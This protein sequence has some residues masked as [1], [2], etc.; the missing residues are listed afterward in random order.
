MN[1]PVTSAVELESRR[2]AI[3]ACFVFQL[4]IRRYV[5]WDFFDSIGRSDKNSVRVK[6]FRFAL[7][8]RHCSMRS[9]LRIC[10]TS[11]LMGCSSCVLTARASSVYCTSIPSDLAVLRMMTNS[12]FIGGGRS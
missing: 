8:L 2:A 6:V 11:G 1:S 9:A 5:F 7:K 3:V 12:N 4:E 10:A